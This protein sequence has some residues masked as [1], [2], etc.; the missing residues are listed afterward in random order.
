MLDR[1]KKMRSFWQR[2]GRLRG[3]GCA[4]IFDADW[5]QDAADV[6][7]WMERPVEENRLYLD[8]EII[9]LQSAFCAKEE[10]A[11]VGDDYR[12]EV[13]DHLGIRFKRALHL[14]AHR[15]EIFDGSQKDVLKRAQNGEP[16]REFSLRNIER[17][18]QASHGDLPCG[19]LTESQAFREAYPRAIYRYMKRSFRVLEVNRR[20]GKIKLQTLSKP[21]AKESTSPDVRIS[22]SADFRESDSGK[23]AEGIWLADVVVNLDEAVVGYKQKVSG[24]NTQTISYQDA[25]YKPLTRTTYPFGLA[26]TGPDLNKATLIAI[27]NA[28]CAMNDFDPSD[29][30]V[31][32]LSGVIGVALPQ[33][34]NAGWAIANKPGTAARLTG[35]LLVNWFKVLEEALRTAT[36][37]TTMSQLSE[38]A[39]LSASLQSWDVQNGADAMSSQDSAGLVRI[40]APKSRVMVEDRYGNRTE[41]NIEKYSY[42][43]NLGWCYWS[44]GVWVKHEYVLEIPGISVTALYN[45]DTDEIEPTPALAA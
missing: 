44:N 27:K 18:Y 25:G 3:E 17:Q 30:D 39:R 36:D 41:A 23:K 43:P 9:C 12:M 42:R 37:P 22:A 2:F 40:F 7:E 8:D 32:K 10:Q 38:L 4:V 45:R 15:D 20:T 6:E 19:S 14:V 31:V 1:P 21:N 11:A 29:L 33:P 13:F 24:G 35:G 5:P 16:H 26:V 34:T 28:Y